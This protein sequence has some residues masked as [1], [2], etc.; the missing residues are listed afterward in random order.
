MA[1]EML[2]EQVDINEV[3]PYAL[4]NRNHDKFQIERIAKSIKEF[5]FNQPIVIDENNE[6]IVGHARLEA[7]KLLWLKRVPV[8]KKK[9]LSA[10]QKKAYRILDNKLQNDSTWNF[11]N[12]QLEL[13]ALS[14]DSFDLEAW[15][16]DV[17][18]Q[19][20]E[21]NDESIENSL[22]IEEFGIFIECVD[23]KEQQSIYDELTERGLKCKL[24]G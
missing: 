18:L 1:S 19:K 17:F 15:G 2:I 8:Y 12:L 20:D 3:K 24:I 5:G 11:E 22:K 16:L 7:A 14:A 13:E 6:I 9:G 23:S 21:S 10:K 4:N